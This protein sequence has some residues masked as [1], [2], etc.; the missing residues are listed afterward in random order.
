MALTLLFLVADGTPSAPML[1]GGPMSAAASYLPAAL[2]VGW[3]GGGSSRGPNPEPLA[4]DASQGNGASSSPRR[5]PSWLH[6]ST[7]EST[8]PATLAA[9]S[10]YSVPA[11]ARSGAAHGSPQRH[12]HSSDAAGSGPGSHPLAFG[13]YVQPHGDMQDDDELPSS[14]PARYPDASP[15]SSPFRPR[16]VCNVK[17]PLRSSD[18]RCLWQCCHACL[19]CRIPSCLC[20]PRIRFHS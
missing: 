6:N 20:L 11:S 5:H 14:R 12:G 3:H 4:P 7:Y 19:H 13:S 2:A 18:H 17:K 9:N 10:P 15:N 1:P 16:K 8:A